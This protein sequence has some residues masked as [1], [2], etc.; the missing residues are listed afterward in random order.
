MK[1]FKTTKCNSTKNPTIHI[2][3]LDLNTINIKIWYD[4]KVSLLKFIEHD[5]NIENKEGLQLSPTTLVLDKNYTLTDIIKDNHDHS[6]YTLISKKDEDDSFHFKFLNLF[7]FTQAAKLGMS[8]IVGGYHCNLDL[9]FYVPFKDSTFEDITIVGNTN[10]LFLN[11]TE[12]IDSHNVDAYPATF[13]TSCDKFLP[14]I[15]LSKDSNSIITAQLCTHEGTPIKKANVDLLFETTTGYLN[16]TRATTDVNGIAHIK[17]LGEEL[18]GKVKV[19][20]KYFSGKAEI[21]V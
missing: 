14:S 16:T 19:G 18:N 17:V 5:K 10:S 2:E 4:V 12:I 15:L 11:G 21:I 9:I 8:S 1:I 13:G 6:A 7:N 20:F 3:Q